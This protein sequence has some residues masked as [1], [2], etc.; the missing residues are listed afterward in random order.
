MSEIVNLIN[1]HLVKATS[2]RCVDASANGGASA[3]LERAAAV[4]KNIW[5]GLAR[6]CRRSLDRTGWRLAHAS[7]YQPAETMTPARTFRVTKIAAS[8]WTIRLFAM[9]VSVVARL[10]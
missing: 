1:A 3:F 9:G 4:L 7:L 2:E 10:A 5:C 6:P 8:Q